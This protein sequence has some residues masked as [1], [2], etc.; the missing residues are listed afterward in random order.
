MSTQGRWVG[1]GQFCKW[2]GKEIRVWVSDYD[3]S[4]EFPEELEY[5]SI[6][7]SWESIQFLLVHR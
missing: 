7:C 4:G 3:D 5:C 1:V 2:C 6:M